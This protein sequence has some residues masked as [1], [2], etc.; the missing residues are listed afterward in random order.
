MFFKAR[1]G[2]RGFTLIEMMAVV[3]IIGLML[4]VLLPNLSSTQ[5]SQLERQGKDL[6]ARIDLARER[7]IVTS[8]PHRVWLEIDE[9]AFRVDWW[10]DESRAFGL[11]GEDD[12]GLGVVETAYQDIPQPISLSPPQTEEREY[13][14]VPMK[15]GTDSWLDDNAYFEGI[16]TQNGWITEGE[17]QLV[18]Q[19]DGSTDYAEL[20]LVDEWGNSVTVEVQ[21]LLDHA[22]V[23][24]TEED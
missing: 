12:D 20:F 23:Y 13:F 14:P 15:F 1:A 10:V 19:I 8:A 16:N 11:P 9:G 22:R 2:S 3:A 24:R 6:A 4:G 7:A 18:F 17:V 21:P 5:A